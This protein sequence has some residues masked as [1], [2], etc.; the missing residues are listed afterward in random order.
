[1]ENALIQQQSPSQFDLMLAQL[2]KGLQLSEVLINS[3]T[4]PDRWKR[5]EEVFAVMMR[6]NDYKFTPIQSLE[7]F[8]VVHGRIAMDSHGIAAVILANGGTIETV[9][10]DARAQTVRITRPGHPP[11]EYRFTIE[12]AEKAKLTGNA[13]YREMPRNMLYARALTFAA[14]KLYA[15][16]LK[17]MKTKEELE[18]M[19]EERSPEAAVG[20]VNALLGAPASE[21][22]PID[23][24]PEK[25]TE[26]AVND[27]LSAFGKLGVTPAHILEY[28]DCKELFHITQERFDELRDVYA[29]CTKG[30]KPMP[31]GA[32]FKGL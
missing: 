32:F 7:V 23:V 26:K 28:C 27:M 17:G 25:P 16:K 18:D 22:A 14:R 21:A 30:E 3:R 24:T 15:D 4:I 12:D 1:M 6:G 20:A 2:D 8:Y 5:K 10:D 9:E 11:L 13:K 29:Q 19:P 31:V